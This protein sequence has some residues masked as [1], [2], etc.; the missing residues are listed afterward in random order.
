MRV[1][2]LE[3]GYE[4][5]LK[6]EFKSDSRITREIR[7]LPGTVSYQAGRWFVFFKDQGWNKA[8]LE[9]KI[10]P[11]E[12]RIVKMIQTG[13]TQA[14]QELGEIRDLPELT[15]T[16]PVRRPLYPYQGYGVAYCL[17]HKRVIIGDQPGLGKTSQAAAVLLAGRVM[18]T[19]TLPALI[20]CPATIKRKWQ[21][22]LMEVAGLRGMILN[23][24][25][26]HKWPYLLQSGQ[27]DAVICN[28]ESLQKFFVQAVT[29]PP[30]A[31]FRLKDIQFSPFIS[32]FKTII[33]DESHKCKDGATQRA[34]FCMG[35]AKG[36]E[37]ILALTGTP[38]VN[39]PFDLIAQ[40][41]MIDRLQDFGGYSYFKARYCDGGK[42]AT[43]LEE[44]NYKLTSTCFYRREKKSVLKDLPDKTRQVVLCDID[45]RIEYDKARDQFVEYLK[46]FK[47]CSDPEIRKKLRGKF[48]VQLGVLREIAARGK[49][50][51]V[52]EWAENL[53]ESDEKVV[54]FCNLTDIIQRL[55]RLFPGALEISGK[56]ATDV[57]DK[58]VA[59]FQTSDRHKVIICNLQAGGV[60]I[61]LFA[62]SNVGFI[63]FPWTYADCEQCEDRLHRNGQ[64]DAVLAAYFLG[65]NT[66]D[67]F[68]YDKIQEKKDIADAVTGAQDQVEE[69]VDSLLN[70]LTKQKKQ[71]SLYD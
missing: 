14:P 25:F 71:V 54:I 56:V 15:V 49:I 22:E 11:F 43:N 58:Y 32:L 41:H 48:M 24:K 1:V 3:N 47:G 20:V 65:E 37:W 67:Q 2:P 27:V 53:L 17:A 52:K 9:K 5:V 61:D 44:L 26:K 55:K 18:E 63:E 51:A 21:R 33:I 45:T 13:I 46:L 29:T 16:L 39:K 40:L 50:L 36:K 31:E 64:K 10:G 8:Q 60:G 69:L 30:D 70:F 62:S 12:R 42:G 6:D 38:L 66:V 57:R 34:K 68:V 19:S 35:I 4:I 59:L 28:F 7:A 23:D